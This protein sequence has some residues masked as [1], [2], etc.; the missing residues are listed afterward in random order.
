MGCD[1]TSVCVGGRCEICDPNTGLGCTRQSPICR[2]GLD[3]NLCGPCGNH[4]E[5]RQ[6]YCRERPECL[7]LA[8]CN[9]RQAEYPGTC[10]ECV[11][12]F[13]CADGSLCVNETCGHPC[14]SNDQCLFPAL[15]CRRGRCEPS[16]ACETLADCNASAGFDC[17]DG[18]CQICRPGEY[19][20]DTSFCVFGNT[21]VFPQCQSCL[22]TGRC[23]AG[24]VC[25][26]VTQVCE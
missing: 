7:S 21:D 20:S 23:P 18:L 26:V 5:C 17:I 9:P 6:L 11:S 10:I 24:L 1:D 25:N 3:E 8:F 22:T 13:L 19:C 4:G 12:N 15:S 2:E 16:Q 14:D